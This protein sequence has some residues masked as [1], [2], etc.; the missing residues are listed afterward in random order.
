[1]LVVAAVVH[2]W[3]A[4]LVVLVA[5]AADSRLLGGLPL[6]VG[7]VVG[8]VDDG[9]AAVRDRV[10]HRHDAVDRLLGPQHRHRAVHHLAAP[11]GEGATTE[12]M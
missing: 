6:G 11:A 7:V 9:E 12:N 1:M 4:D 8:L 3:R 5:G 2:T 10:Q